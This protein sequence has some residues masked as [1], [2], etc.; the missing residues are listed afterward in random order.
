MPC[1]KSRDVKPVLGQSAADG[2]TD[3]VTVFLQL[4]QSLLNR[5]VDGFLDGQTNPVDLVH[6]PAG[7]NNAKAH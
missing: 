5:L 3:E 7:L 4:V 2:G 1:C 6:T